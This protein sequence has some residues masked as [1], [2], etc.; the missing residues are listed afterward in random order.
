MKVPRVKT[1]Y[2]ITA[3]SKLHGVLIVP[4]PI[5]TLTSSVSW[6]VDSF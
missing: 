2:L 4:I 3:F 6:L 5:A 1:M